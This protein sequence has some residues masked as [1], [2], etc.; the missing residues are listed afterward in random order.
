MFSARSELTL[1]AFTLVVG[2]ALFGPKQRRGAKAEIRIRNFDVTET[3][4]EDC[5][6]LNVGLD[7]LG[8]DTKVLH[9]SGH[10]R[11]TE[12]SPPGC[13]NISAKF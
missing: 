3:C 9:D 1:I 12:P 6:G 13:K 2:P 4:S 11:G 7:L 5:V 8:Q 10:L